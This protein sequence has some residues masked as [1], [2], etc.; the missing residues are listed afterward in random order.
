MTQKESRVDRIFAR[1]KDHPVVAAAIVASIVI[2]SLAELK[3]SIGKLMSPIPTNTGA[4]PVQTP[5]A[6][7]PSP[8]TVVEAAPLQAETQDSQDAMSKDIEINRLLD[9]A[10]DLITGRPGET[11][12]RLRV[13]LC[14]RQT[15][16]NVHL[17]QA[18][19]KIYE[20]IKLKDLPTNH[21]AYLLLGLLYANKDE[22]RKALQVVDK[23]LAA[24]P[25]EADLVSLRGELLFRMKR[26]EESLESFKLAVKLDPE[27]AEYISN[28]SSMYHRLG[29]LDQAQALA[30][31]AL[32]KD[33]YSV[34][35]HINLGSIFRDKEQTEQAIMQ[36]SKACRL[37]STNADAHSHLGY[38]MAIKGDLAEA[39]KE[40][41]VAIDLDP[42]CGHYFYNMGLIQRKIGRE[43][44]AKQFI[45]RAEE[46]GVSVA[47][48]P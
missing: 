3:E 37:D 36:F 21:R 33:P 8:V 26:A 34:S 5:V 19:R 10:Q 20:A 38:M 42:K 46:L 17:E 23:A 2:I 41:Q 24:V 1:L 32:R 35:G 25:E 43:E 45:K 28:L 11:A 29:E 4:S 30:E 14:V 15:V 22:Y 18:R 6:G 13:S 16:D 44:T 31:E 48:T 9:D 7:T 39:A 40:Y 12:L 27:N 47:A